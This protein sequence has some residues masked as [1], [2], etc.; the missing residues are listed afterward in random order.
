MTLKVYYG[1]KNDLEGAVLEDK[2]SKK[3]KPPKF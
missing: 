3:T 2:R 1:N